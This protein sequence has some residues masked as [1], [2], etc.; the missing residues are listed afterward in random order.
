MAPSLDTCGWFTRDIDTYLRVADVLLGE[1]PQPLPD[2]VRLLRSP[3][4]DALAQPAAFQALSGGI[5]RVESVLGTA[6]ALSADLLDIESMFWCVRHIQGHETWGINRG[7]ITRFAPPLGPGVAQRFEWSSQVTDAQMEQA[8]AMRAAIQQMWSAVLGHD[9]VLVL[10]QPFGA[11]AVPVGFDGVSANQLAD[12][13]A[14]RCAAGVVLDGPPWQRPLTGASGATR[15][16]GVTPHP[17]PG[18]NDLLLGVFLVRGFLFARFFQVRFMFG[19]GLHFG[20]CWRGGHHSGC[21][22]RVACRGRRSRC[23]GEGS[24][25]ET[26][27]DQRGDELV[28]VK[29]FRL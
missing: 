16:D 4:L 3:Q 10:P 23:G 1:D 5:Q 2:R 15:D 25:G 21:H 27:D 6:Q 11:V 9:A 22:T 7:L 20:G 8:R 28:H 17:A 14:R 19:F 13:R 29:S 18:R 24:H 26:T 12:G